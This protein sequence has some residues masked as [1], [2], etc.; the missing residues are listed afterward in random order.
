MRL[1]GQDTTRGCDI[2]V[3]PGSVTSCSG[4]PL[5]VLC[6]PTAA[7]K[8]SLAV[9][10][11]LRFGMIAINAD[12][13]QVC[14]GLDIGTGKPTL[15]ERRGVPHYLFDVIGPDQDYNAKRFQIEADKVIAEAEVPVCVVGGTFLY[16]KALLHGLFELPQGVVPAIRERV[17]A[18]CAAAGPEYAHAWLQRIDPT[19]AAVLHPNDQVRLLRALEVYYATGR[20]ISLYKE[21]HGFR[22]VRYR[23]L[24]LVVTPPREVLYERIAQRVE[25]MFAAGLVDEV[26]ALLERGLDPSKPSL[27]TI[28]YREVV[29]HLRSGLPLDQ[30]KEAIVV[31]TRRY[32]K[33]QLTWLRAQPEA[34]WLDPLRDRERC[35]RVV[36]EFLLA[37]P[38]G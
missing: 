32:A 17:Q 8:T 1:T 13:R 9:E 20:P 4:R 27:Q 11:G 21:G 31:R 16:L 30:V 38:E 37:S 6:G 22:E 35:F 26:S 29:G 24:L 19:S 36:E 5:V 15:A 34:L 7:G 2:P 10:L 12:S 14:Q 33:A 18:L 25:A 28:G 23:Y 3:V